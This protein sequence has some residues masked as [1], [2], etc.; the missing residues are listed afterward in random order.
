MLKLY[1]RAAIKT[2]EKL[3]L[4]LNRVAA[5]MRQDNYNPDKVLV[6]FKAAVETERAFEQMIADGDTEAIDDYVA[7][8]G[9]LDQLQDMFFKQF[10]ASLAI[11]ESMSAA[12]LATG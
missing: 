3:W 12:A 11:D 5:S 8:K 10:G 1:T 7:P 6:C 2:I 9:A 4:S